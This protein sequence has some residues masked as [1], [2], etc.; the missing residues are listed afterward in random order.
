[1]DIEARP[2]TR[3]TDIMINGHDDLDYRHV[4]KREN[5]WFRGI[6]RTGNKRLGGKICE[7][8]IQLKGGLILEGI[9]EASIVNIMYMMA[10]SVSIMTVLCYQVGN[11]AFGPAVRV[12]V[13]IF[14][15]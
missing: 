7:P 1:M 3:S 9:D 6:K 15:L 10:V 4:S 12:H 14:C 2:T 11:I 5:K 8:G 13:Y